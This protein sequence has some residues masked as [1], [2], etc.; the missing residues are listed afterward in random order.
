[1]IAHYSQPWL[2]G[3][4]PIDAR[5][6]KSHRTSVKRIMAMFVTGGLIYMG[7]LVGFVSYQAV[8]NGMDVKHGIVYG[9]TGE[10]PDGT[11][12]RGLY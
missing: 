11:S 3:M 9:A 5:S 10:M 2:M 1:M 12:L 7:F 6:T 4:K 8:V